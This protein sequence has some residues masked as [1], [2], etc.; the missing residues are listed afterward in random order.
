[1]NLTAF[2]NNRGIHS[3]DEGHSQQ[4]PQQVEDLIRLTNA[5]NITVL[6]IGFNAGHSAEVFLKNNPDLSLVSFDLGEYRYVSPGKE[7][8]DA[9][10]PNRHT[11]IVGDSRNTIPAYIEKNKGT[12]FD[13]IFIDGGHDYDIA[14]T[15]IEN[16]F[17]LA[18]KNTIV[19]LDDTM[20]T[21]GWEQ[22]YTIG[23]TQAWTEYIE[24][25][26]IMELGRN[27]YCAGRGMV[28]GKYSFATKLDYA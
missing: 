17:H 28:W 8:I 27:D 7:Y 24:Q 3:F 13:F 12:T 19:A 21:P 18:H 6:E 9:T 1:M 4:V 5:P 25:T 23:P 2:L 22:H 10:Y 14:K 20:F 16:C 11:L 26:K 15:D